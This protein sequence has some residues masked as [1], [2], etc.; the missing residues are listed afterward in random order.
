MENAWSW[1]LVHNKENAIFSKIIK[2]LFWLIQAPNIP[3][4]ISRN[5]GATIKASQK[6]AHDKV[7]FILGQ[8]GHF[9]LQKMVTPSKKCYSPKYVYWYQ[10]FNVWK[11]V[12][13]KKLVHGRLCTNIDINIDINKASSYYIE[14]I[15]VIVI[16]SFYVIGLHVPHRIIGIID[17]YISAHP[18]TLLSCNFFPSPFLP[19]A[20]RST[21]MLDH[22]MKI[23]DP[24]LMTYLT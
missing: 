24:P 15:I 7:F 4:H 14:K 11:M 21:Y 6:T 3:K 9:I 13:A 23:L 10:C 1:M 16:C 12:G 22:P 19:A 5:G 18:P 2:R 17:I 20:C 8:K